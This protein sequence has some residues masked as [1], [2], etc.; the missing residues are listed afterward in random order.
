MVCYL[1]DAF[2]NGYDQWEL[3]DAFENG[4]DRWKQHVVKELW[5][6]ERSIVSSRD[7]KGHK[8]VQ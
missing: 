1:S 4:Y 7:S 5:E 6:E 8:C 2:K 3:I